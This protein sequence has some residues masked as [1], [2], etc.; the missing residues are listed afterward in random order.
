MSGIIVRLRCEIGL[1]RIEVDKNKK[2]IDLKK[3]IEE[4]LNVPTEKQE[5]FLLENPNE[6]LSDDA[7]TLSTYKIQ[8][9]SIVQLRSKVKPIANKKRE[10]RNEGMKGSNPSKTSLQNEPVSKNSYFEEKSQ[11]K[12]VNDD[13]GGTDFNGKKEID[14]KSNKKSENEPNFKSF[15]Y[16]LKLRGYNTTDLPLNLAY[17][18]VYLI[19]GQFNKIPLSITL[20]HQEYRHVDH[21]E[22]MNVEEIKNFVNYWCFT[23]NMFEQRAGWMYG[24]YKED[25]HYNL[26]IRAVCECIYE[27]PQIN[28]NNKIKLL[29]DDFIDSVDLIAERLGLERIGWIFTHL[30]RKEYLTSDEVVHIAKL[31]LANIKKNMHYTNYSVSN[32]ITCTI[33]PDPMLSNEPVTNAFM[34]SDL[35]MALIRDNL[36]EENQ[37]DPSHV[38]LRNPNKNEL[39]PQ[40]LEGGKETN[41]FDT[42]WFIVRVNESA[43]KNIRSIFKN[44]HFPRENRVNAQTVFDVKEYFASTKLERGTNGNFRCSDFHLILFVSKVLDIETALA[45]CDAALN[46]KEIDPIMEEILTSVKV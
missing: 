20:K 9:G 5:L 21:L 8:N 37:T 19:K 27:P 18:S 23:N 2:L 22:L 34:V 39:L 10:E 6:A 17:K 43:P 15:D 11:K 45:L 46:K 4:L 16:F 13:K 33:S 31:Q 35:G 24:Y 12:M 32:F 3:K 26:G 30:P 29:S 1:Y 14:N 42:D 25:T 7:C 44:F 40:I 38:Q 28:E 36:I 41:K